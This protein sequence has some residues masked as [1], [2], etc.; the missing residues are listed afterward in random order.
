MIRIFLVALCLSSST[1][2]SIADASEGSCIGATTLLDLRID[3]P[4]SIPALD[5]ADRERLS[6]DLFGAPGRNFTVNSIARGAFTRAGAMQTAYLVQ[7]EGPDAT[8]P[9]PQVATLA[10]YEGDKLLEKSVPTFGNFI[11]AVVKPDESGAQSLLLRD[12]HYQMATS[13]IRIGLFTHAERSWKPVRTFD[14][15]RVDRCEDEHFGGNVEAIVV[16]QCPTAAEGQYKF[17]VSRYHA[18]CRDQQQPLLDGFSL[19]PEGKSAT[20]TPV[21]GKP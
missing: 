20:T 8:S 16:E 6:R 1:F 12:E 5:D 18:R 17:N 7:A 15:A 4:M 14:Q 3:N 9:T 2:V 13:T 11:H 10:L 19:M 21:Q